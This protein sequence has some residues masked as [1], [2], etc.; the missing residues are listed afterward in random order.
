VFLET[1]DAVEV[2]S[3]IKLEFEVPQAGPAALTGRVT[4]RREQ[5]GVDGPAGIGVEFDDMID[6]LGGLIDQLVADFSGITVMLVCQDSKDRTTLT[7]QLKSI[8]ST[9]EVVGAADARVAGQ[10]LDDEIDLVLIEEEGSGE[11][12]LA[13]VAAAQ[14]LANPVPCIF[15]SSNARLRDRAREGGAADVLPSPPSFGELQN[16]VM[17][18]LGRPTSVNPS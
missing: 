10:L 5:A 4:W 9:A 15:L 1:E 6:S 12:A 17:R 13:V 11:N 14:A 18:V 8:I 7:R 16:A 2:G 3:A